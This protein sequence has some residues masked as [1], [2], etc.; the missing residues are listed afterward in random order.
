MASPSHIKAPPVA[1][2]APAG[3]FVDLDTEVIGTTSLFGA[4]A[5]PALPHSTDLIATVAALY[6]AE[7][8]T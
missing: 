7:K 3:L 1:L 5:V 2:D 8:F 4:R 6:E